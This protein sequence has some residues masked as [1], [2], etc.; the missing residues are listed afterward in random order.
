MW[1]AHRLP[2]S[3]SRKN[4][5]V[6]ILVS[7]DRPVLALVPLNDVW[8]VANFKEDQIGSMKAGQP[9]SIEIDTF[10]GLRFHGKWRALRQAPALGLLVAPR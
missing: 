1:C 6:G 5:E 3:S 4:V 8:I 10:S 2:V 7:P 9:A